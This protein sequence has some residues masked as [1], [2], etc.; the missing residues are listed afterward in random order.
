MS[1]TS[2][3]VPGSASPQPI[4]LHFDQIEAEVLRLACGAAL[5]DSQK[6]DRSTSAVAE[7]IAVSR[8]SEDGLSLSVGPDFML[9][10]YNIVDSY[11]AGHNQSA[12]GIGP[13]PAERRPRLSNIADQVSGIARRGVSKVAKYYKKHPNALAN[14][15]WKVRMHA[16]NIINKLDEKTL[17][18]Q[19]RRRFIIPEADQ[20]ELES[21]DIFDNGRSEAVL[22]KIGQAIID[23]LEESSEE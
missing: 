22:E 13:G 10:L 6:H 4:S 14:A 19:T 21:Y 18:L 11:V 17:D 15:N 7:V 12:G 1:Q 3:E 23:G 5:Q 8:N 20:R 9:R 2:E 16:G